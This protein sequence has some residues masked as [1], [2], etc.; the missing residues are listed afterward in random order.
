MHSE[1]FMTLLLSLLLTVHTASAALN[2]AGG[3]N[4]DLGKVVAGQTQ[5]T[6]VVLVN[7]SKEFVVLNTVYIGFTFEQILFLDKDF[8]GTGGT[9]GYQLEPFQ[10]CTFVVAFAPNAIGKTVSTFIKFSYT[11]G[12]QPQN[13]QLTL[14]GQGVAEEAPTE[15]NPIAPG[16]L[17]LDAES[18]NFGL[19]QKGKVS[20][21]VM[22]LAN[23]GAS[24][25]SGILV[26]DLQAPFAFPGGEYPG[27]AGSCGAT[28]KPKES[29]QMLLEFQPSVAGVFTN[30]LTLQYFDG[31][32]IQAVGLGL[33]GRAK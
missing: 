3:E 17:V 1:V 2:I 31:K 29:C 5:N 10:S 12:N 23:T 30:S 9:C 28:L 26:K 32:S 13:L 20:T 4:V 18:V 14:T 7:P 6:T 21:R 24:T 11:A 8:P 16:L 19:I 25:L 33:W 15:P 22:T 27:T